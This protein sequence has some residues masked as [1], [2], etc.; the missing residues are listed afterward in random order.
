MHSVCSGLFP[1]I[2]KPF[3]TY[4]I[5]CENQEKTR[6]WFETVSWFCWFPES[7]R[8]CA[9]SY[10]R[11]DDQLHRAGGRVSLGLLCWKLLCW[12]RFPSDPNSETIHLPTSHRSLINCIDKQ[13]SRDRFCPVPQT[14]LNKS[15]TFSPSLVTSSSGSML[16]MAAFWYTYVA[17]EKQANNSLRG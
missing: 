13:K 8:V 4:I 7:S 6:L 10:Q 3:H 14:H 1:T 16:K 2:V 17:Y 11:R 9:C 5:S 15:P 12:N